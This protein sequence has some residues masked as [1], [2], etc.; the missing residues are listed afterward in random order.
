MASIGC[1]LGVTVICLVSIRDLWCVANL[2][3][4]IRDM[5][6]MIISCLSLSGIPWAMREVVHCTLDSEGSLLGVQTVAS[7]G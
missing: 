7:A 2:Y 1:Q 6:G 5:R 3:L 4:V